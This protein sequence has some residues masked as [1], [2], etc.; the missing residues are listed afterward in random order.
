MKNTFRLI[1]TLLLIAVAGTLISCEKPAVPY[2]HKE[3]IIIDQGNLDYY[4]WA[5]LTYGNQ[6]WQK[7]ANGTEENNNGFYYFFDGEDVVIQS[8]LKPVKVLYFE[9]AMS[10]GEALTPNGKNVVRQKL[11]KYGSF[12]FH[13]EWKD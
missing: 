13:Y 2:E 10:K 4:S 9:T 12:N 8:K 7:R 6:T 3:G 5:D 11:G 1:A